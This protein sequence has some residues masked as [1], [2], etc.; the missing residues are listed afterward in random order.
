MWSMWQLVRRREPSRVLPSYWRKPFKVRATLK[1]AWWWDLDLLR[2]RCRWPWRDGDDVAP[3]LLLILRRILH[4]LPVVVQ[5][6]V[7]CC[8]F[9]GENSS[10]LRAAL[11]SQM[12][13][14]VPKLRSQNGFW[15]GEPKN[16]SYV[17][18]GFRTVQLQSLVNNDCQT[19][20]MKNCIN[21]NE[22]PNDIDLQQ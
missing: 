18:I 8:C 14:P 19:L 2:L 1:V 9:L 22:K 6:E 4:L 21:Y 13:S 10:S 16:E 5:G 12:L 7:Y 20:I 11:L 17:D 3:R 15:E